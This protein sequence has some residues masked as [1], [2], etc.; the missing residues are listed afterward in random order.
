MH[1][2]Q[3]TSVKPDNYFIDDRFTNTVNHYMST[4]CVFS[5]PI[6]MSVCT[7]DFSEKLSLLVFLATSSLSYHFSAGLGF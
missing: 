6:F 5:K 1:V 2:C 4:F 7:C 3:I